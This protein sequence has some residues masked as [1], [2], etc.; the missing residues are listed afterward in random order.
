[1]SDEQNQAVFSLP[2]SIAQVV[3]IRRISREL[4]LVD[5]HL[6]QEFLKDPTK[7]FT[8]KTSPKL[9]DLVKTNHIDLLKKDQRTALIQI[10]N[11]IK[12][13]APTVNISFSAEANEEFIAKIITWFRTNANPYCLIIVGLEPTIGIGSL[14]RTN[15]KVFDFSIKNRLKLTSKQLEDGI[16]KINVVKA[17]K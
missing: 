3:D 8:L 13:S 16:K 1:M 10:V 9:D 15:N 4:N 14:V 5:E 2:T 11:Q 17:E 7:T 6:N 12:T